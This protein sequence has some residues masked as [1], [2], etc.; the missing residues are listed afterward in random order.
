MASV[1]NS[2]AESYEGQANGGLP[3][4][5]APRS[6]V[7]AAHNVNVPVNHAEKPEKFNGLNFK[8]WQQKMFF[9]LTTLN[10]GRF[11]TEDVPNLVEG[12]GDIQAVNIVDA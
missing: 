5:N 12:E 4:P 1:S 10:L 2:V 9:Y 6:N 7:M 3:N 11:L 8:R